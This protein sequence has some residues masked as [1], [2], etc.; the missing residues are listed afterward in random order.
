MTV[1]IASFWELA[2][3]TP[4]LEVDLYQYPLED[5]G[6]D[7]IYMHPISGIDNKRIKERNNLDEILAENYDMTVVFVTDRAETK[8]VNFEHPDNALY[9]TG[10]TSHSDPSL[11][12]V[13]E[14]RLSVCIETPNNQGGL[15]GHQALSIVLYDRIIKNGSNS[16]R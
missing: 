11:T 7:E 15:W 4:I 3:N 1:K 9:I 14:G 12:Y 6:V 13:A 5:F 10:L 2:W 8:L 16:N